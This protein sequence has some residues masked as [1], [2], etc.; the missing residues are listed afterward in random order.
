M[1]PFCLSFLS[2]TM[3]GVC[4][5]SVSS[6]GM[7]QE[8]DRLYPKTG[9]TVTGQII[10]ITRDKVTIEVRGNNQNYAVQDIARIVYESEPPLL[11]RTKELVANGQWDMAYENIRKVDAKAISRDE[12]KQDYEFYKGYLLAYMALR[13]KGDPKGAA[14]V[15][16]AY[17]K[18]NPQSIHYYDTVEQLGEL[19]EALGLPDRAI[20]Y[21]ETLSTASSPD[22]KFRANYLVGKTLLAQG[23]LA[24]AK[25]AFGD[26]VAANATN[27]GAKKMQN[28]AKVSLIRCDSADKSKS[29]EAIKNLMQLVVDGDASDN[30]L[31]AHIYNALGDINRRE[32]K[33]EEA[34]IA[35]L[36]TDLL[37]ASESDAHAEALYNLS[38]IWGQIGDPQRG[39]DAKA[40]LQEQYGGTP[41]AK[42]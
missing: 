28:M 18:A 16:A 26:V 9:A 34:A 33:N 19:A 36:H 23:K 29:A 30:S 35:F 15:L 42:K 5:L 4:L 11:S 10:E 32:G 3:A 21:Y 2:L 27:P 14:S 40:R 1:K 39:A 17:E 7:S 13:G 12:A 25:K 31:M 22:A 24:E 38:Q 37:F 20:K 6:I 41:W 8:A